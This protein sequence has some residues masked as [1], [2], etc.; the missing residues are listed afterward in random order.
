MNLKKTLVLGASENTERYA[1]KAVKMLRAHQHEVIAVGNREGFIDDIPI[2]K[3]D[4]HNVIEFNNSISDKKKIK[5]V[6]IE[7]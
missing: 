3:N 1:N 5:I 4:T 6:K 7:Y 2:L